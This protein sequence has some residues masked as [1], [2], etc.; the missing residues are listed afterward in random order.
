MYGGKLQR[1]KFR[2][3]G[4]SVEAV[5]NRRSAAKILAEEDGV[6]TISA[7]VF[8]KGIEVNLRRILKN[9]KI[10]AEKDMSILNRKE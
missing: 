7:E 10:M 5:L 6:Y 3:F 4:C 8:G 9:L 1:I 2:Y